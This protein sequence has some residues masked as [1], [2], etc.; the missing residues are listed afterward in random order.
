MKRELNR[1]EAF[2]V[3]LICIPVLIVAGFIV[4]LAG[5]LVMGISFLIPIV[6]LINPSV[7]KVGK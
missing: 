1:I 5:M 4:V 7:I 3:G 2:L 6:A